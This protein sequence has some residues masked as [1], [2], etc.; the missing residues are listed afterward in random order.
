[1]RGLILPLLERYAPQMILVSFGFDPH[2]RD[3]LGSLILSAAG[4]GDLI[5]SLVDY[6]EAHCEGK[7]AL[8][9]EGGYDLDAAAACGQAAVAALLKIPW[10]D[11][12]GPSPLQESSHW[13]V[14]ERRAREIWGV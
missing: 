1:M 13:Q 2:W 8:I 5:S 7:I 6:A 3:P 14:M 10:Q 4:Y 9:L 11:T 12:L